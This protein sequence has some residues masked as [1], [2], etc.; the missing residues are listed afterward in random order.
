MSDPVRV[1]RNGAVT[2]VILNR[3]EARNAVNGPTAAA[4]FAA[5][6]EFDHDDTASVV[7]TSCRG[8]PVPHGLLRFPGQSFLFQ[9]RPPGSVLRFLRNAASHQRAVFHRP[10]VPEGREHLHIH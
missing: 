1:E 2:T 3:P 10:A 4:L 8:S 5:F 9:P 7:A 6:E